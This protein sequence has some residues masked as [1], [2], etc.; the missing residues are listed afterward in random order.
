[1]QNSD[2]STPNS[3]N[4]R[5]SSPDISV[6]RDKIF[7]V[8][9]SFQPLPSPSSLFK[10]VLDISASSRTKQFSV[11]LCKIPRHVDIPTLIRRFKRIQVRKSLELWT[12]KDKDPN[13]CTYWCRGDRSH[14]RRA[15]SLGFYSIITE[16]QQ[17]DVTGI[18]LLQEKYSVSSQN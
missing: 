18:F 1:M 16:R 12:R 9:P 7:L 4:E 10:K 6:G 11:A 3:Q 15:A 5:E 14:T 17:T 2:S 8:I 13:Y